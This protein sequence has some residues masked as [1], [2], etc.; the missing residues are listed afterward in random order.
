MSF[1]YLVISDADRTSITAA[2]SSVPGQQRLPS[3]WALPGA[4]KVEEV[5]GYHKG[6]HIWI[7]HMESC[8][9]PFSV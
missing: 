4:A 9:Y 3:W 8:G 7:S 6:C 1:Q 2:T 5:F